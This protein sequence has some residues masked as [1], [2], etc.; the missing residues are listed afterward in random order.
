ME[1]SCIIFSHES[2]SNHCFIRPDASG[3]CGRDGSSVGF[4]AERKTERLGVAVFSLRPLRAIGR[5]GEVAECR[6]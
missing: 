5:T 6:K 4:R 1:I 2:D 3:P